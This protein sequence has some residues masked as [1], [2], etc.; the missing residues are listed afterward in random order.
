MVVIGWMRWQHGV[1]KGVGGC[2]GSGL[3]AVV[4]E[5]AEVVA[6]IV[7]VLP[8][9]IPNAK[10]TEKHLFILNPSH[11]MYILHPLAHGSRDTPHHRL[12]HHHLL[13]Q[14]VCSEENPE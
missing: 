7:I 2:S 13:P 5:V 11:H 14:Y 1:S 8:K 3:V 6:P 10:L 9:I 12:F 4:E